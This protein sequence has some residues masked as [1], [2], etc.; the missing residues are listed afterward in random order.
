[1]GML[2]HAHAGHGAS[3]QDLEKLSFGQVHKSAIA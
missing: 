1:M 2:G 3:T